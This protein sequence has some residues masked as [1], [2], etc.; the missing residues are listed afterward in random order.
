MKLLRAALYSGVQK[1]HRTVPFPTIIC[2]KKPYGQVKQSELCALQIL[3]NVKSSEF[4]NLKCKRKFLKPNFE[5]ISAPVCFYYGLNSRIVLNTLQV[6]CEYVCVTVGEQNPHSFTD[7]ISV[8]Q[9]GMWDSLDKFIRWR[10]GGKKK[11]G[12]LWLFSKVEL[13]IFSTCSFSIFMLLS[14]KSYTITFILYCNTA[15]RQTG[16]GEEGH[17]FMRLNSLESQN[18][19][20]E[21][22]KDSFLCFNP[23]HLWCRHHNLTL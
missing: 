20:S 6:F 15:Q 17:K 14:T 3:Q 1:G 21:K 5:V 23:E 16:N 8:L 11:K 4:V 2:L 7:S 12:K 22:A 13:L 18:H 9:K 10:K 19:D